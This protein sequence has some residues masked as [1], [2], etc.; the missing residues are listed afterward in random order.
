MEQ[1]RVADARTERA[2]DGSLVH[3][4]GAVAGAGTAQFTLEPGR[5]SVAC[6]HPSVSEVWFVL[7]GTGRLW[8]RPPDADAVEV[9]LEP[10]LSVTI[11]AGTVFQFACDG[12]E[13]LRILGVTSPPWPG[14]GEAV[15]ADGPWDPRA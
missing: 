1:I 2:P 14:P 10:G 5:V 7:A 6:R 15:P 8:R 9:A 3:V 13:P 4:L 11:P 12:A